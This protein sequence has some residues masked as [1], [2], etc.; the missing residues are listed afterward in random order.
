MYRVSEVADRNA[1]IAL[2]IDSAS[3]PATGPDCGSQ[4]LPILDKFAD[5]GMSVRAQ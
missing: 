5:R 1:G 3:D 4:F 2:K